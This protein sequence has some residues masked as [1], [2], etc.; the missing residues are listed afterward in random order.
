MNKVKLRVYDMFDKVSFK[1][2]QPYDGH[3]WVNEQEN[4]DACVVMNG[5]FESPV[6]V[7][8][9]LLMT[10]PYEVIRY[11][12]GRCFQ[13]NLPILKDGRFKN[14]YT[15]NDDLVSS[16]DFFIKTYPPT[17]TWIDEK[18]REVHTKS[19]NISMI[20]S[21]KNFCYGHQIRSRIANYLQDK[22][23]VDV[24]GRD[25]GVPVDNKIECKR[26][27]RFSI[28]IENEVLPGWHTEKILDCFMTGTI[29][30]YYGDPNIG[31]IYDTD[32]IVDLLSF[33]G[34][35]DPSHWDLSL[36]EQLNEEKY[37]SMRESVF[38]NF[39]TACE[40]DS[41]YKVPNILDKICR[42]SFQ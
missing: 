12:T 11:L 20:S 2:I 33:F 25:F 23:L 41:Q 38:R 30:V 22:N 34:S 39:E 19:K 4:P 8:T 36:L 42:E 35:V 26:D 31:R 21:K 9:C 3:V 32:G 27:Y 5:T 14:I 24:Y 40:L 1:N 17:A 18:D 7:Q 13:T 29:P 15:Y 28:V 37:E 10:E 6:S 16:S